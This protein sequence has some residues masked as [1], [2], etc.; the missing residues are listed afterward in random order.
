MDAT[1]LMELMKNKKASLKQKEKTLKPNPGSNRYILLPGWRK[2][3]EHIWFHDYGQH[4][5]KNAAGE[6]QAVYP[7]QDKIYQQ[8]CPVCEG[9][10]HAMRGA[11]EETTERLKE[12]TSK[13]SYLFNVL[14]LDG[15]D[16]ETPKILEVGK[17]VFGQIVDL[18]EEWGL[19]VFDPEQPQIITI[20]R[21]GKGFNTKYTVQVSPK[22]HALH[23]STLSKL[24]N[25]DDYVRQE[26]EEQQRRALNAIGAVAGA[27]PALAAP[28]DV[29]ATASSVIDA[30]LDARLNAE[31]S[32]SV[33][34]DDDLAL[35]AEL[36][37]LLASGG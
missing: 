6:I 12:A 8:P 18:L 28:S 27:A 7:C 9:L 14:A 23:A 22:K 4:Y 17:S 29:P 30:G 1:K 19:S 36:D 15:E 16:P 2:G 13:Q 31:A 34:K 35:D 20:N 26:N 21:D 3:E 25:L 11:D 32:R 37:A 24:N 33:V 5:V 10:A